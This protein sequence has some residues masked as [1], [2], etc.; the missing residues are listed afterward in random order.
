MTDMH[1]ILDHCSRESDQPTLIELLEEALDQFKCGLINES[2][3]VDAL[4]VAAEWPTD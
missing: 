4:F 3:L 1:M 2:E